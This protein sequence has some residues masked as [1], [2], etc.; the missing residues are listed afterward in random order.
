MERLNPEDFS[1]QLVRDMCTCLGCRHPGNGQRLRSVLDLSE[2]VEISEIRNL[3]GIVCFQMSD[4]HLVTLS[5]DQIEGLLSH[6]QFVDPRGE[7]TK[8]LWRG[9][10]IQVEKIDWNQY[11]AEPAVRLHALNSVS[12]LGF[13]LLKNVPRNPGAVIEVIDTFGFVRETNY[14]EIFDVRVEDNPNN[15]AF[16]SLA[17]APHTDNPYRDPVPTLQLLHCLKATVAG[18]NSALVDGFHVANSLRKFDPKAFELLVREDFRFIYENDF[19]YLESVSPVIKLNTKGE[20]V[21]VRWNDRSMQSPAMSEYVDDL[22]L[23]L[24]TFAALANEPSM[25][26]EFRLDPGDCVIFDNTRLLHARSAYES[27]GDRHLQGAYADIDALFSSIHH[28][29]RICQ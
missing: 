26:F 2:N 7:S 24:K 22:F 12:K 5:A 13:V 28:L 19:A 21:E 20:V 6:D 1:A 18:G 14:G 27:S 15:L 17:I 8:F 25:A 16:T 11:L 9:T 3:D 23:A 4:D 10:E 29:E